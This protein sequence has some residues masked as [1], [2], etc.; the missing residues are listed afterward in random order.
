MIILVFFAVV[1]SGNGKCGM[2]GKQNGKHFTIV[3]R[4]KREEKSFVSIYHQAFA[5]YTRK[6]I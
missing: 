5:K 3:Q 2:E 1:D 6:L 4:N